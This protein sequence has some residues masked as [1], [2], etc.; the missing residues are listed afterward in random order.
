MIP[1]STV[2]ALEGR[3]FDILVWFLRHRIFDERSDVKKN[4]YP[5]RVLPVCRQYPGSIRAS[6][7]GHPGTKNYPGTKVL[8]LPRHPG[9]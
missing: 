1:T 5:V 7:S 8:G 2:W 6:V 9:R 4:E 3:N